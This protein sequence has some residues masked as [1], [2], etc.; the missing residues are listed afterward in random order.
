MAVLD[1]LRWLGHDGFRIEGEVTIYL[2]PYQLEGGPQADLILVTHDHFDHFSPE[3]IERV[4]GPDTEIVAPP[5]VVRSLQGYRVHEIRPGESVE[6]KGV[7]IEAVPAYNVDK[8]REPGRPFHP[9]EDGKVGFVVT[10]DGERV[11]HAGDSDFVP[12]MRD[13]SVDIAL[14]PVSG[15]FVMTAEEAADAARA[16]RPRVAVPM[17]FGSIVASEVEAERFAQL[18]QGEVQVRIVPKTV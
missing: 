5:E 18:L 11:Y 2:D 12:E 14:L 4:S 16:I 10:V 7:R 8:F 3:D 6:A 17:H 1:H 15:T 9:K 13:L